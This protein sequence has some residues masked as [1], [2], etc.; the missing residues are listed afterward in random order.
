MWFGLT[1]ARSSPTSTQW[2]RKTE[3]STARAGG[4]TPNETLE[5]PSDVLTPG[6]C[7]LTCRMPSMVSF[8]LGRQFSIGRPGH[9]LLVDR[10]R[11]ERRSVGGRDRNHP[12]ELVATGLEVDR[13]DDRPPR[14][15]LQRHLDHLGL[16]RVDLDGRGLG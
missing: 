12:V 1:I 8:A 7:S 2:W 5:T 15:L 11:D 14:D 9:A 3:L 16:G 4:D 6:S 13:V 10:Q